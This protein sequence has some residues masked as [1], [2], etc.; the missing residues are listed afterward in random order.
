[1]FTPVSI[2]GSLSSIS[3]EVLKAVTND[4]KGDSNR[5]IRFT[6]INPPKLGKLVNVQADKSITEISSFTQE[7]V[8]AVK[9]H[10]LFAWKSAGP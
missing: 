1:M 3:K 8:R 9:P 5:T 6:V 4:D 2:S 7:M 10:S